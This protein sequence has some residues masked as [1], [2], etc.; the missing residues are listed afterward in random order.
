MPDDKKLKIRCEHWGDGII[1]IVALDEDG[2][3]ITIPS[4]P[5]SEPT[6]QQ[7]LKP[8]TAWTPEL[9]ERFVRLAEAHDEGRF[10]EQWDAEFGKDDN[11][12]P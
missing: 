1:G 11:S 7:K 5:Y 3:P 10:D 12:K 6:D 2:Q 8:E 4:T 9:V